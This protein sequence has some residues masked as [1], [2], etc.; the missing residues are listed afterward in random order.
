MNTR[1]MRESDY[2]AIIPVVNE[3]W[4]GR[5]MTHLLPR[6]FFEHFQNTSFVIENDGSIAAFLIGFRSQTHVNESYIH[7]VGVHPDYRRQGIAKELYELFFSK[8][9]DMGCDTA[10][11]ITS[12]VNEKSIKFHSQMGFSVSL[13]ADYAG[14]GEDYIL[15]TK[16]L[17]L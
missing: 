16:S 2:F 10:R 7:F 4:G 5:Q 11:C 1:S 15:F 6:L 17:S 12:P 9:R 8:V 13:A 3:W 14:P